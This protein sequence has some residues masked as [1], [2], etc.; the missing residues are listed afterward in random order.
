MRF[1]GRIDG[2]SHHVSHEPH[3]TTSPVTTDRTI[4]SRILAS[5]NSYSGY[6]FVSAS[7]CGAEEVRYRIKLRGRGTRKVSL[8]SPQLPQ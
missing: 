4:Q 7:A 6:C 1:K 8:C 3:N 2:W 5:N